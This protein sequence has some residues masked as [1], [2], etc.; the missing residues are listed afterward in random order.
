MSS[1]LV[2]AE[3]IVTISDE[4]YPEGIPQRFLKID[5]VTCRQKQVQ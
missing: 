4:I 2:G 3:G 1:G 5:E